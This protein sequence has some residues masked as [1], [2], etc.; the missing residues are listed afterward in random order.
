MTEIKKPHNISEKDWQLLTSKYP[1]KMGE[2]VT[3]I[4]NNYPIQYLIGNVEFLNVLLKVDNRVL[5]P[6]FETEE[7]VDKTIKKIKKM[8]LSYPKIIDLGTGSGCIAIAL[9]K[10]IHSEVT[11]VDISKDALELAKENA[12]NNQVAITFIEQDL[13]DVSLKDYDIIISNPPYVK[14]DEKVGLETK[15]EPQMALF[16]PNNGLYFYELILKNVAS[17]S[18]KPKLIAFEIGMTQGKDLTILK[19]KYLPT[20]KLF[21]EKDLA[22]K[23]RFIFLI[24]E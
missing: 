13:K 14:E 17:L 8:N 9:K 7:L 18:T 10:N 2:I 23:D 22:G 21:L 24:N 19:N 11:A 15:Y 4:A 16:A 5:I 12:Y 20:Y 6:R 3:K 1:Q